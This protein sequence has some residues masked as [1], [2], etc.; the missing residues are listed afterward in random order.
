[1]KWL[2]VGVCGGNGNGYGGTGK[3][4]VW[5]EC[6]KEEGLVEGL[7]SKGLLRVGKLGEHFVNKNSNEGSIYLN[8]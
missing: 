1:M 7:N 2:K 3:V 5:W 6:W 4:T 8:R